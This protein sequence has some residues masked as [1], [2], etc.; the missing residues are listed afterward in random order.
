LERWALS[1]QIWNRIFSKI[2]RSFIELTTRRISE[3]KSRTIGSV[4]L[5]ASLK[6][7]VESDKGRA[8]GSRSRTLQP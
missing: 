5:E 1:K 4:V 7:P 8:G 2:E 6:V 3:P